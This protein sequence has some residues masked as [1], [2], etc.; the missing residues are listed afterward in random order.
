MQ[1]NYLSELKT[2]AYRGNQP[3]PWLSKNVPRVQVVD[4][5]I[6]NIDGETYIVPAGYIWDGASIPR[7][8]WNI[9][10]PNDPAYW[11]AACFHDYCYSHLYRNGIM[12]SFAD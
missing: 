3:T 9:F 4:P 11:R 12:K 5:F 7:L 6:V 8:L 10:P 1:I 2:K